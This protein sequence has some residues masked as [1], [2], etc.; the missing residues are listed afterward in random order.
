MDKKHIIY[1]WETGAKV[2]VD[3]KTYNLYTEMMKWLWA[4][5]E[6][7][8]SKTFG[9]VMVFGTGGDLEAGD[10]AKNLFTKPENFKHE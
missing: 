2:E 5:A 6:P 1:D 3:E 7:I 8:A 10:D 4:S 9:K